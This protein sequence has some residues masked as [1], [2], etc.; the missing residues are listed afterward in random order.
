MARTTC[1]YPTRHR[2]QD[3]SKGEERAQPELHGG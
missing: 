2:Q 3:G 1:R